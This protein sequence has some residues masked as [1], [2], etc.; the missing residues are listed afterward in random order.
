[1]K[2][3]EF[4]PWEVWYAKFPYE[5]D[6]TQYTSRPVIVLRAGAGKVLAVKVTCHVMRRADCFDTP[7]HFWKD[8]HLDH[9]SVARVS[10]ATEIA[11]DDLIRR[12]GVLKNHD[13]F[14]VF[15]AYSAFLTNTIQQQAEI[16]KH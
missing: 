10:K 13:A 7:L 3:K 8:A 6:N 5:E 12:I 1:M 9:P 14:A 16:S 15:D 11:Q 2:T 4:N